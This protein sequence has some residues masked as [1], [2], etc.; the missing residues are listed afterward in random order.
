MYLPDPIDDQ[1][2]VNVVKNHSIFLGSPDSTIRKM[3]EQAEKFDDFDCKNSKVL[4]TYFFD[5][6]SPKLQSH[7]N[8][9]VEPEEKDLFTCVWIRVLS[10]VSK[11]SSSFYDELKTKVKQVKPN[12]FSRENIEEWY[13]ALLPDLDQLLQ[14]GKYEHVI[15]EHILGNLSM[16][17][18][19]GGTFTW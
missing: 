4:A 9:L 7:L 12:A 6:L 15:T 2:M 3:L 18:S 11:V 8:L 16:Y 5:S 10:K 17:C 14:G 19:V 1:L 13:K